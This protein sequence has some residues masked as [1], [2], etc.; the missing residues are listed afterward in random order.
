MENYVM[1][2]RGALLLIDLT[3]MPDLNSI[4]EWVKIVRMHDINLPILLVGTKFDL[5]EIMVVDDEIALD[6][7]NTS[8]MFDYIKTSAKTGYNIN[9][10]FE[11]MIKKLINI[12]E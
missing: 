12:N 5:E 7:R 9:M 11:K 8:T 6:I 1:G 4:L 10:V 3:Q 2:A